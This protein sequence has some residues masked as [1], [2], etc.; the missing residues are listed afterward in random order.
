MIDLATHFKENVSTA[1]ASL[2]FTITEM[3]NGQKLFVSGYANDGTESDRTNHSPEKNG[4]IG[5][6]TP[7]PESVSPQPVP[8]VG[9]QSGSVGSQI[10]PSQNSAGQGS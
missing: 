9:H 7:V 4:L 10:S 6:S 2:V 5:Y 3:D 8:C 1:T